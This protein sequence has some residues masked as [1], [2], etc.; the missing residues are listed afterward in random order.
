MINLTYSQ[1]LDFVDDLDYDTARELHNHWYLTL[2]GFNRVQH[3]IEYA[4]TLPPEQAQHT[5]EWLECCTPTPPVLSDR[6]KQKIEAFDLNTQFR[7]YYMVE[8]YTESEP[9]VE[10]KTVVNT[11]NSDEFNAFK[12]WATHHINTSA[13]M[14]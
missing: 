14:L 6:A 2:P 7:L 10:L 11:M 9:M 12:H 13:N 3:A 1:C 8:F 5:V 4:K